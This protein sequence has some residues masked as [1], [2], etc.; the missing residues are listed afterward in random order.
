MSYDE[1][2]NAGMCVASAELLSDYVL[3]YVYASLYDGLCI[4]L[5]IM[6]KQLNFNIDF[7][8]H[9]HGVVFPF[10]WCG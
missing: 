7:P 5:C 2:V 9:V 3:W 1:H 6:F 10:V 4:L 8:V